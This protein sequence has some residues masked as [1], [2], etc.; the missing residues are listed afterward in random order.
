MTAAEVEKLKMLG[1][2]LEAVLI[3]ARNGRLDSTCL[4][5]VERVRIALSDLAEMPNASKCKLGGCSAIGCEG[6]HYCF[7]QDGTPKQISEDQSAT[8]AIAIKDAL[9]SN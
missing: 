6:G 8:L 5:T 3:D 1:Y 9:A 7:D 2:E 4:R